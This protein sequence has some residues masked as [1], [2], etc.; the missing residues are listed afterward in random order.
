MPSASM[1]SSFWTTGENNLLGKIYENPHE[2]LGFAI[3]NPLDS[4]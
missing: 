1:W 4:A 2:K 3:S